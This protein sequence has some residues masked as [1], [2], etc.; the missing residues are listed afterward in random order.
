MKEFKITAR[1]STGESLTLVRR[2]NSNQEAA[3]SVRSEGMLVLA[4]DEIKQERVIFS[5]GS[6]MEVE[7]SLR[8]ISSMLKSAVTLSTALKTVE[9]QSSSPRFK[10][11]WNK[12]REAVY[13]GESFADSLSR[14]KGY[15]D[16][17]V[18]RLAEV[19]EKTGELEKS[20]SRA[21]DQLESRRDLKT[22]VMNAL[23]YPVVAVIMAIAVS[24]YLV[25]SVIP[26][27]GEFLRSGGAELPAITQMLMDFS[28]WTIENAVFILLTIVSVVVLWWLIRMS[29]RGREMQDAMLMRLPVTGRILRLSG[30]ALFSRSMQIMI[31]SGV[32][33]LDA[34]GVC[35]RLLPNMRLRRRVSDARES[36]MRGAT[37]EKSLEVATE[38]MPMLKSM[39]A[40]G[41]ASG[42]IAETFAETARF[43]E[44]LLRLAVK[45]FGMLIE[46]V[47][48]IVTGIIVGFVYVAFFMALFAIASAN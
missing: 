13:S 4:V 39:V 37:L 19:G 31:E 10:K 20:L 1:A 32:T 18:V 30:T 12:V 5:R 41:E 38:F 14:H 47:M 11:V 45:R 42:S 24:A 3:R 28:D 23:I 25:V 34:L 16:E 40:V 33:L 44:M 9:E 35:A 36:V 48:I 27:L 43:H 8:Q 6:S 17:M 26:K 21:A 2:A 29:A 15:F 46:P 7:S 22:A